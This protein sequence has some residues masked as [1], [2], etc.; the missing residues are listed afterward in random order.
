MRQLQVA[1]IISN[2]VEHALLL[3][4]NALSIWLEYQFISEI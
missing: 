1:R 3:N 4:Y 2:K